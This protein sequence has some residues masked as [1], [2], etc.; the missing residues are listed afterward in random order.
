[1]HYLHSRVSETSSLFTVAQKAFFLGAGIYQP[2]LRTLVAVTQ[3]IMYMYVGK[4][5][6]SNMVKLRTR[7]SQE[8]RQENPG[9][10]LP[11]SLITSIAIAPR[12]IFSFC[13]AHEL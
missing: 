6:H 5:R 1:M 4:R 12:T 11:P 2:L 9:E 10:P 3:R 8:A 13:R 7:E